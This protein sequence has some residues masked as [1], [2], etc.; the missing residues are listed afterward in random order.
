MNLSGLG[1]RLLEDALKRA[2]TTKKVSPTAAGDSLNVTAAQVEA[3][4]AVKRMASVLVLFVLA[5]QVLRLAGDA[6]GTAWSAL[7]EV[8]GPVDIAIVGDSRAHVGLSPGRLAAPEEPASSS[9]PVVYNFAAD[10]TDALHHAS[11]VLN[12]LLR[13]K[14]S[15]SVILWAP[16]PLSFN[17]NRKNNRIEQL[18]L[19]DIPLL[20]RCG[21]PFETV[22]EIA[23]AALFPPYRQRVVIK[24]LLTEFTDRAAWL[25]VHVQTRLLKMVYAP[26]Q[27]SREY[28]QPEAGYAPFE[29]VRWSE[30]FER[31]EREY[32][33]QYD[34]ARLCGVRLETSRAMLREARHAGVHVVI[35]ELP[36]APWFLKHLEPRQF[37]Q[38]WRS[39]LQKIALEEGADFVCDADAVHRDEEFGDPGHMC[40]EAA[41]AYSRDLGG[42]LRSLPSVQAALEKARLGAGEF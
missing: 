29:I 27:T 18:A 31:G 42:R 14:V 39:A 8:K 1:V 25:P 11:F 35:V 4:K 12:G 32:T 20:F 26:L 33:R 13:G 15:P 22:L 16:N 10:G 36:I 2:G 17:E 28:L 38:T 3:R 23:T 30:A 24:R 9:T 7:R 21:A 19:R 34:A 37:H 5:A 40:R 6:S 41:E